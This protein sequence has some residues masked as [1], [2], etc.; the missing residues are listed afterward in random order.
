MTSISADVAESLHFAFFYSDVQQFITE[1]LLFNCKIN[2]LMVY[3]DDVGAV[4]NC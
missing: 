1:S 3:V 4:R 2:E